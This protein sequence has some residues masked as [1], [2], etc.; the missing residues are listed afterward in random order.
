MI[1]EFEA[2]LEKQKRDQM[3]QQSRKKDENK[4][5]DKFEAKQNNPDF[6]KLQ[7]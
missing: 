5:E 1:E 7:N 2:K 6:R 4:K 3:E